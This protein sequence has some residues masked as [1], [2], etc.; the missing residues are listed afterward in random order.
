MTAPS[1]PG[2]AYALEGTQWRPTLRAYSS[3]LEA[4][5]QLAPLTVRNYLN[6]LVPFLEFLKMKGASG[7]ARADRLF[8]RSYLAWLIEIG[9]VRASTS[10]KLT[11]LRV[12]Y[13]FLRARGEV[14]KDDTRQVTSPKLE[15][16]LPGVA[17]SQEVERLLSA[18]DTLKPGGVR[19]RALL[20]VLYAAGL[21][22]S[23]A[24]SLDTAALDLNGRE[25]RVVGKGSKMRVVLL[26]RPAVE[27]LSRYLAEVRPQ[28]AG[29]VSGDAVFLNQYGGRLSVRSI[30]ETVKRCALL[31]GLDPD[32]HT[33][34]LRHSFATHLL[35]GGADLRVVQ[36]L[37][38]HSSPATTQVYTHV[39]AAQARKVY[40]AAHPRA[41]VA[42]AQGAAW[43]R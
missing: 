9:Y 29:R 40:L 31:A 42:P 26:G 22:V 36:D 25:V 14:Q 3:H 21:R 10:R 20:E 27:W 30:Q 7:F 16:R 11:A 37:L 2:L 1:I 6:D 41:K 15:R 35:D 17:S 33:H 38:G 18:P 12:F 28:W 4:E 34:T 24:H 19:D 43:R 23:E 8:L 13:Q 39:S 5:R 32:F